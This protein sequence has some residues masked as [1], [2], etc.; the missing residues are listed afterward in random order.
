M[1]NNKLIAAIY[2]ILISLIFLTQIVFIWTQDN[3]LKGKLMVVSGLFLLILG[4]FAVFYQEQI[5]SGFNPKAKPLSK[6][7]KVSYIIF[8]LFYVMMVVSSFVQG[9][10]L[11]GE[12]LAV[13]GLSL[14]VA[15]AFGGYDW[16]LSNAQRKQ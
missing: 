6:F 10:A 14:L 2:I 13:A 15:I 7:M 4:V 5:R 3:A 1:K 12:L 11:K 8:L 9:H 16:V